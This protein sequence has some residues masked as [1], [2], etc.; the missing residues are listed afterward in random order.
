M[1]FRW[2]EQSPFSPAGSS[3]SPSM[4]T[5]QASIARRSHLPTR[6]NFVGAMPGGTD[7]ASFSSPLVESSLPTEWS[8]SSS[9]SWW[10]LTSASPN[11]MVSDPCG[12]SS[13]LQVK[14]VQTTSGKSRA[15]PTKTCTQT[16]YPSTWRKPTRVRV[17]AGMLGQRTVVSRSNTIASKSLR[18][19]RTK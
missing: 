4:V 19:T 17:R 1:L 8:A 12:T 2:G 11:E 13:C 5:M 16:Q 6:S 14:C 18:S 10:L 3:S 15:Q 7:F 9:G